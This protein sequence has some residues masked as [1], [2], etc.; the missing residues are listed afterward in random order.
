MGIFFELLRIVWEFKL[1][2]GV[3]GSSR[4][5]LTISSRDLNNISACLCF[6]AKLPHTSLPRRRSF[7][8]CTLRSS[9]ISSTT[10]LALSSALC[11]STSMSSSTT[12][13]V[14]WRKKRGNNRQRVFCINISYLFLFEVEPLIDL[15]F[16]FFDFCFFLLLRE[17]Q[18]GAKLSLNRQFMDERWSKHRV[19]TCLDWSPQVI[20]FD[21]SFINKTSLKTPLNGCSGAFFCFLLKLKN[22]IGFLTALDVL[23]LCYMSL[24]AFLSA[25]TPLGEAGL[26]HTNCHW[27]VRCNDLFPLVSKVIL[28]LILQRHVTVIEHQLFVPYVSSSLQH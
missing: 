16:C 8:Y 26:S 21:S 3:G 6:S 4:I 13:V 20:F 27:A 17:I 24:T 14:T 5:I 9:L 18:A 28:F 11:P 25:K 12:A 19:V 1:F 23:W 22:L 7:R 15:W 10:A 2:S